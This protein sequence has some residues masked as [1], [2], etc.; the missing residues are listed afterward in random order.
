M[1]LRFLV[2]ILIVLLNSSIVFAEIVNDIKVKGNN[3]V[4]AETIIVFSD[5]KKGDDV[6]DKIL[7]E[8]LKELYGTNFFKDVKLF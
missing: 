1:M 8:S 6:T 2:Y 7:N 3:R 5:I 4:S